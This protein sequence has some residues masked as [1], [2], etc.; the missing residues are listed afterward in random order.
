MYAHYLCFT[1]SDVC[2]LVCATIRSLGIVIYTCVKIYMCMHRHVYISSRLPLLVKPRRRESM[3]APTRSC[4]SWCRAHQI[5]HGSWPCYK[6]HCSSCSAAIF[7][8]ECMLRKHSDHAFPQ[9]SLLRPPSINIPRP[10]WN[11]RNE[12]MKIAS[13]INLL[14][15]MSGDMHA[16]MQGIQDVEAGHFL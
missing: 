6:W 5:N 3:R 15:Q 16:T 14:R 2:G 13:Y 8:S 11:A 7:C 10:S 9:T 1:L 12:S 4:L